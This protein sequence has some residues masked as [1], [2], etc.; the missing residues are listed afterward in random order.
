MSD[1]AVVYTMI[2]V[3][4]LLV[5]SFLNVVI[6]RVPRDE[7]LISP[8]SHCPSCQMEIK[9]WHNVPVFGW[10]FLRGRCAGCKTHISV[11]YP[12]VEAGTALLFVGMAMRFGIS[13]QLPAY[14]YLAAVAVALGLIDFDVRRLPDSIVLPSYVVAVL[15][16]LPAGAGGVDFRAGRGLIAMLL[17]LF[18]Y[19]AL[20]LAYPYGLGFGDVKL[21]GVLGLYLGWN[22]WGSVVVGTIAGLA[23]A[24]LVSAVLL[25]FGR[26]GE[27][28]LH[29]PFGPYLLSGAFLSLFAAA[30]ITAWSSSFMPLSV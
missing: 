4:G 9:P 2:G 12:L 13:L 24:A 21:A 20:A 10:L 22:S 28:R 19:F 27:R 18:I 25:L 15:L 16:L 6:Y 5:G 30:P 14:L 11:R 29:I 23:I 17:V 1:L 7:S 3:F 26:D 8:G